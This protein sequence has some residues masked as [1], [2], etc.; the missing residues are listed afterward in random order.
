MSPG[1]LNQCFNSQAVQFLQQ[2][3]AHLLHQQ[4]Y[5]S[6]VYKMRQLLLNKKKR[7]LS[8]YKAI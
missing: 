6:T 4:F 3:L 8:E 2:L 5:S 7:E 1:G